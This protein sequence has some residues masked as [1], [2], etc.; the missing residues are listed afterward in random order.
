M[1]ISR[2]TIKQSPYLG[3]F[4]QLSENYIV[5]P[6]TLEK[7]KIKEIEDYFEVRAIPT[8]IS[9]SPLIGVFGKQIGQK[10]IVSQLITEK[11]TKEIEK[12]G[13]E[14]KVLNTEQ[15]IGNLFAGNSKKGIISQA[16][17]PKIKKDIEEFLGI[18]LE[19]ININQTDLVGSSLVITEKGFYV[20]PDIKETEYKK[21]EN[22]LELKG[23]Y[24]SLNYGDKYV[25]NCMIANTK[26]IQVGETSTNNEILRIDEALREE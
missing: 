16:I 13:I 3:I 17:N 12:Q 14:V 22:Y 15:A 4:T 5:L 2:A 11:E 6:K 18:K 25:G 10:M 19:T 8:T 23:G 1:K 21:L 26:A 9:E 7:T 20:N 24:G